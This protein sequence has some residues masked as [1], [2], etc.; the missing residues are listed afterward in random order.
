MADKDTIKTTTDPYSPGAD[1][2]NAA[3]QD[4]GST[5]SNS[6]YSLRNCKIP[7]YPTTNMKNHKKKETKIDD[8]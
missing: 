1:N 8:K 2:L 4:S 6:P 7:P 5:D 3:A